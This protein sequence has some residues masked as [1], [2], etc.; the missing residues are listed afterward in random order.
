MSF[1]QPA[2]PALP[3]SPAPKAG[4]VYVFRGESNGLFQRCAWNTGRLLSRI[5]SMLL[6][7]LHVGGQS[8]IPKTG[9][10]LM[11]TNPQSFLDP[12][13]IGIAPSRQ[14]HY[15]A[16]DTLFKGGFLTWLM[17][18]LNAFPVKR[19]AADLTAIRT[20]VERLDK[21]FLLNIFPEGTRSEDGSIGHIA[22]G[23]S[24]ILNR[25]KTD[26]AVL[27]VVI[28]GAFEAWPRTS[29]FPHPHPIRIRHGK[30]IAA[31]E[32]RGLSAEALAL[33]LR[34]ELVKLQAGMGS[35]HAARSE[36]RLAEAVAAAASGSGGEGKGPRR[37][38]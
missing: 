9:G 8:N 25:C 4:H 27:P 17:E 7:R 37:R 6:F 15:M 38:R 18:L 10:V 22:P 34:G 2:T 11:V 16:R 26:V 24:L 21:G 31:A 3:E 5:I 35:P 20:A 19:G 33:R 28:D 14:V 1:G 30:P 29:R 13:L 23:I 32:W 12:W 36:E